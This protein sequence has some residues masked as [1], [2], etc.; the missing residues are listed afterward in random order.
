MVDR[1]HKTLL[2]LVNLIL[3]VDQKEDLHKRDVAL[4]VQL[5]ALH[6]YVDQHFEN[7]ELLLEAVGGPFYARQKLQHNALRDQLGVFWSPGQDSPPSEVIHDIAVWSKDCLL[8][9]FLT[10]DLEAF[11]SPP[12]TDEVNLEK[13]RMA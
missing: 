4:K 3:A 10:A 6:R 13:E 2:E 7:E 11:H 5:E 12:F 8:K 1:E 9:H